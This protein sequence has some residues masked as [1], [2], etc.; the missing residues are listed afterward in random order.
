[1]IIHYK[2]DFWL[3]VPIIP[4]VLWLYSLH[5]FILQFTRRVSSSPHIHFSLRGAAR[6][7]AVT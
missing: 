2:I 6:S 7:G 4:L 5:G 1:M 3:L